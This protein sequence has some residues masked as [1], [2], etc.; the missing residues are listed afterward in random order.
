MR[1]EVSRTR[2]HAGVVLLRLGDDGAYDV[3]KAP[4]DS[5]FEAQEPFPLPFDPA[6]LLEDRRGMRVLRSFERVNLGRDELTDY[7]AFEKYGRMN[8]RD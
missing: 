2:G 3:H 8:T 7:V 5:T 6:G 1:V 4:A